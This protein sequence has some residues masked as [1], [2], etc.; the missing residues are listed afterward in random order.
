MIVTSGYRSPAKNLLIGGAKNSAHCQCQACDF[1]DDDHSIKN[2]I[3][4]NLEVLED[5][6]LYCE[7]FDFT[8]N[9]CHLQT[10]VIPSGNRI[11]NP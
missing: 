2:F 8:P 4:N 5:C 1:K 3:I 11:F 6:G 9:W 7:E 10:R